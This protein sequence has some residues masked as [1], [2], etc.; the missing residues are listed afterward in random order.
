[1]VYN[2]IKILNTEKSIGIYC[3]LMT[4]LIIRK[5]KI[6]IIITQKTLTGKYILST[7]KATAGSK[8]TVVIT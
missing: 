7:I 8:E 3:K 4:I 6:I 5:M 1:M 2:P